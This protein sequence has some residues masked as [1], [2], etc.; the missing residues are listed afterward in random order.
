MGIEG[1]EPEGQGAGGR[2]SAFHPRQQATQR[3]HHRGAA[4]AV[5]A[6]DG[7]RR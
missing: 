7:D 1:G 5:L 2:G 6:K 3:V 4:G